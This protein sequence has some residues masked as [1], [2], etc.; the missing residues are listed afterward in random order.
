MKRIRRIL[1]VL[2][3]WLLSFA[4]TGQNLSGIRIYINPGHGGF[5]SDDR[6]V[7][8]PPYALGDTA[9]FWESKS[10]LAKGLH[11][12]Q[13]LESAGATVIMSRVQ[14][15][16]IDDRPLSAIAEEANVNQSDFMISIHSN[17]HNSMTNYVL[18]LF[19]G[20]DN[21]PILPQSM[22][23]AGLFF[24]N[25]FSNQAS[26]WSYQGRQVRGDKSFAPESWN[27]YGVLRPLTVPGLI[28]EGSFHDYLPETYRLM[29]REYKQLEAWHLFRAFCRYYG[30]NPGN[31]G[32]IAGT[33]KDSYRKVTAYG[34]IP[35]SRDQWLPVN[36]ATVTLQPG[37]KTYHVDQ[38]NNGFF[39]FDHLEPGE[40][41]LTFEAEKYVSRV[42]EK[43]RVDSAAVTYHLCALEQDRSDSMEV[44]DYAPRPG[45][46]ERVSAASP[47]VFRF[48]FEV[49]TA[50]FR[51][52]FSITPVVEGSFIW[53]DQGRTARFVPRQPLEVSTTY[54][55]FL[56]RSVRHI[57]NLPMK[58]DVTFSFTTVARNRLN[59]LNHYPRNGMTDVFPQTQVRLHL[60]GKVKNED[61]SGRVKVIDSRGMEVPG[62]GMEINAFPG[63][64]GS[65]SFL[66]NN[67][68]PDSFY[69]LVIDGKLADTEGLTLGQTRYVTFGVSAVPQVEEASVAYDFEVSAS[70]WAI[71]TL[72]S[73]HLMP[74]TANRILRYSG[75]RL[76]GGYSYRLLYGFSDE[77]AR[78]VVR[79]DSLPGSFTKGSAAGLYVWGDLSEN[80]LSLLFRKG[81]EYREVLLTRIDFAGWQYRE[82]SPGLPEGEAWAFDGFLLRSGGTPFSV[83]GALYFDNLV[84]VSPALGI[85]IPGAGAAKE[86]KLAFYPNPARKVLYAGCAGES[87]LN[88]GEQGDYLILDMSGRILLGGKAVNADTR[89]TIPIAGLKPGTYL[90]RMMWGKRVDQ[91]L[92]IIN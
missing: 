81:E 50:S 80:T 20:W 90:V 76:F 28:S 19:H 39:L 53:E 26:Q 46:G 72:A 64:V 68:Q 82:V 37:N 1:P 47:V 42:V 16:T 44:V 24:D 69:T 55:V 7:P 33:V 57:G 67:L 88:G 18:M 84:A 62:S 56:A 87:V 25:L 22:Q 74:G 14:N 89:F 11:L 86:G 2:L 32:K 79:A 92:F 8:L 83:G 61:L 38:L 12:R 4:G 52:A 13:L 63:E 34:Y 77:E 91:G 43:I 51:E 71:D 85:T 29:N 35:G 40:Y 36:G 45:E 66:L 30:G 54:S 10:N 41:Q 23:L 17:A 49:D 15:R 65:C 78:V 59:L 31:K 21:N 70:G 9:G 73:N 48:N 75:S 60:D 3:W 5:D 58:D 6:N 27:G